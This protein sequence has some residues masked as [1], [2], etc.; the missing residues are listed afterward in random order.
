MTIRDYMQ[1]IGYGLMIIAYSLVLYEKFGVSLISIAL[2]AIAIPIFA[3]YIFK[4]TK[5][6]QTAVK[7]KSIEV[8]QE[9]PLPESH[10]PTTQTH[11]STTYNNSPADLSVETIIDAINNAP[12]F[13][14]N[15]IAQNYRGIYVK[16]RGKLW[17]V[18]KSPFSSPE[19][20][21]VRVRLFTDKL[22]YSILFTVSISQ[23]PTLK[24]LEKDYY[25]T[26]F[27]KIISCSGEGMSVELDV[28]KIEFH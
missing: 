4:K 17:D 15:T 3:I 20:S 10:Q 5:R 7:S 6:Q 26:V 23:Y 8:P 16:W 19:S 9:Q 11:L 1:Y 18:E 13:Q 25:I 2:V 12:P 22:P 28:E 27:G 24:V 14:R 21:D